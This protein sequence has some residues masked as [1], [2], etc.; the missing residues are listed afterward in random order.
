VEGVR[1]V[2]AGVGFADPDQAF[3]EG[4]FELGGGG[5]LE[6]GDVG[7]EE[8]APRAER[9]QACVAVVVALVD[10]PDAQHL[11]VERVEGVDLVEAAELAAEAVDA[12]PGRPGQARNEA[13]AAD[14]AVREE[15][16][17]A[18]REQ[19]G[20]ALEAAADGARAQAERL[21]RLAVRGLLG[22][23]RR[24]EVGQDEVVADAEAR[25][26]GIDE[27]RSPGVGRDDLHAHAQ[28]L[29]PVAQRVPLSEGE[30]AVDLLA[31]SVAVARVRVGA[32]HHREVGRIAHQHRVSH[33]VRG[34][35]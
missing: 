29:E 4:A 32:A 30:L 7:E 19:V 3:A 17:V 13:L 20:L 1:R 9:T 10:Q 23:A 12:L 24:G 35:T 5:G 27:A 6:R 34:A 25:V 18:G 28:V 11:A 2:D 14:R 33:R 8:A 21:D 22:G 15:V 26:G 16:D 31:A